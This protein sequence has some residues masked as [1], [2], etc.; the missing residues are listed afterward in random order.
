MLRRSALLG[1]L[2][3]ILVAVPALASSGPAFKLT[4]VGGKSASFSVTGFEFSSGLNPKVGAAGSVTIDVLI[5]S[6]TEKK[7]LKDG[8]VK[9]AKLHVVAVLPTKVNKTYTF[10]GAKITGVTFVTGSFG[11]AAAVVLSYRKLTV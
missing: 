7:L 11:P 2:V 6:A 3:A 1:L 10:V 4:T 8:K 5:A 9:S